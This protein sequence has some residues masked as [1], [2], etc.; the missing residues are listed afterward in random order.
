MTIKSNKSNGG[1]GLWKLNNSFL[2]EEKYVKDIQTIINDLKNNDNMQLDHVA[3]WEYLKFRIR[4]YSMDYG[5]QK[6]KANRDL[7]K[8]N[9]QILKLLEEKL[10]SC[11]EEVEKR[12]LENQKINI[13]ANLQTLDEEKTRGLIL[14]SRCDWYE[15]G[16]K[17]NSYF[18]RL[19][20]RNKTKSTINKLLRDDNSETTTQKEILELTRNYYKSLYSKQQNKTKQKKIEYLENIMMPSLSEEDKLNCEGEITLDELSKVLKTFQKNKTPG[21]DG[22]TIEF[23]QKF[24]PLLK[25]PLLNCINGGYAKGHLSTSQRQA[26]ITLLDKGKD[27]RILKNWRPIS[28]LNV[29]YKIGTKAIAE[30]LK[31]LLPKIIHSNQVGYVKGRQ[32]TDNIRTV[33]DIFFYTKQKN[34]PGIIINIDFQ[35]AFDSV[36]W[37]FLS[38]TLEKF[39]FGQSFIK[40]I[41]TFYNDISSC[42]INNGIK[43]CH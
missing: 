19:C 41:K 37:E 40:W 17:S 20:S 22:I 13:A 12:E 2:D 10:D 14:R 25:K 23:Y 33:S 18:L 7:E 24:W 43:L 4:C 16:E 35:K 29:D 42:V 30:R 26:V 34:I 3:F 9:E 28:L 39:N 11:T 8:E 15:Q 38:A 31:Q 32:I 6:A 36:D 21:N 1:R 5:K 27:R